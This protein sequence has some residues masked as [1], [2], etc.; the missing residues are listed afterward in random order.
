VS[1]K[2]VSF[3][4]DAT[5]HGEGGIFALFSL[6][7]GRVQKKGLLIALAMAGAALLFGD[8]MITP[9]ISVLSR[10]NVDE[11]A[12]GGVASGEYHTNDSC[13]DE[14]PAMGQPDSPPQ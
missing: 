8:G 12:F 1:I 10:C 11:A 13:A 14:R 4:L 6:C 3:L 2:Y 7:R 5:S 9:A